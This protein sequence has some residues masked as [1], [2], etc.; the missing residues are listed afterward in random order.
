LELY[1]NSCG[2]LQLL[3]CSSTGSNASSDQNFFDL[4][5]F[6]PGNTY[7]V[8]VFGSS[9]NNNRCAIQAFIKTFAV[10]A[11]CPNGFIRFT[12]NLTGLTY[13]WQVNSGS[14]YVNIPPVSVYYSG[15]NTN[16]LV[17]SNAPSSMYGYEYRCIVNG[18]GISTVS[19]LKFASYWNGSV[20]RNWENPL[21]WSCGTVPDQDT[22]VYV[23][24]GSVLLNSNRSCR[25]FTVWPGAS[26]EVANGFALTILK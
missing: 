4:N 20:D 14:G 8:R 21:N 16:Q 11:P 26:V 12:S 23:T 13:Q 10:T 25:S 2:N 5:T 7:Y 24:N 6:I 19:R 15:Y 1:S 18:T 22:D 3:S 9:S 17:I